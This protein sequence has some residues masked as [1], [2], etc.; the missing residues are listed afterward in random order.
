M[1]PYGLMVTPTGQGTRTVGLRVTAIGKPEDAWPI[2]T[3]PKE[4][5]AELAPDLFKFI[6]VEINDQPLDETLD[7]IQ[8][9]IKIPFLY[10][11]N[12]L[13]RHEVDLTRTWSLPAKKTFYKKIIDQLLFQK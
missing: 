7:V 11:H 9:A 4:P 6:N 10:D 8:G 13:A 3:R 2:G 5:P 12:A 1:R